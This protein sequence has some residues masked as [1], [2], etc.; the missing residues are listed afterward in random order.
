MHMKYTFLLLLLVFSAL[1]GRAQI[2][3]SRLDIGSV[4]LD[5]AF[6]QT[7]TIKGS[8]LEKMPFLNLSDAISAWLYGAYTTPA[9]LRYVVDGNPVADVNAYSIFDV[10]EVVL[11]Q[12]AAALI[13]TAPGQ[14]ELVL[15]R[16][17]RRTGPYGVTAA[18][19]TGLIGED[20]VS[21]MRFFHNYY[22][23]AYLNRLKVSLGVSAN[24][25]RDATVSDVPGG[26]IVTPPNWQRWR[27]NGYFDWR[28]DASNQIEVTMNYT[29][30]QLN[31]L[32][33]PTAEQAP[34]FGYKES[35]YQHYLT[36]HLDWRGEW[37]KGWTNDLQATYLHSTL[38]TGM[39]EVI[40]E[41]AADSI[42]IE[43]FGNEVKSYHL[44]IRDHLAFTVKAGGWT[45][46]PSIN[47]S[48]EHINEQIASTEYDEFT[49]STLPNL[50]QIPSVTTSEAY[51]GEKTNPIQVVP[52]VDVSYKR[53][54]EFMAGA[55]ISPGT[56]SP[57]GNGN[58]VYPYAG[59]TI[60]LLRLKNPE[61][62]ESLK[63]FG[64]VVS[65][66]MGS[67][68]GY[69]LADF[70]NWNI[71]TNSFVDFL[72]LQLNATPPPGFPTYWTWEA[73]TRYTGVNGR[74]AV[75]YNFEH[76]IS[77]GLG[78]NGYGNIF[79][80]TYPRW[81]SSLQHLD[82]RVKV[83]DAERVSW[84]SGFNVTVLRT[85]E[86]NEGILQL[87]NA[88]IGDVAPGP[89]T[90]TGGWVNRIQVKDFSAGLDLLYH[91]NETSPVANQ[92]KLNS[93]ATPNV[94]LAYRLHFGRATV[95]ELFVDSRDLIQS[96]NSDVTDP[97]R[98]YTVGGKLDL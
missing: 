55:L 32:V 65:R 70:S 98:Y 11:V 59:A 15:I 12:H 49:T 63:L 88:P 34:L 77:S 9:T 92:G 52:G 54:L 37:A 23:G 6:T 21:K 22:A 86:N 67:Y 46:E 74:L 78:T 41:S 76:R 85:T 1:S 35:G 64:S 84:R 51:V 90:W 24:Y 39:V 36:P 18:A 19:Q 87:D 79:E 27:L 62:D 69:T 20:G 97:R 25:I 44:W 2:D 30:Q 53:A 5:K 14:T 83:V 95:L 16:T 61:Q 43:N 3:T 4:T 73:G 80:S 93:A 50:N 38:S 31:G 10:E 96:A 89:W 47:L 13:G 57:T 82:I 56:H 48:Y 45:I 58:R 72:N 40:G 17:K 75:S 60:D 81:Y 71:Q 68:Q 28:P 7:L 8:D 29:P 94:Y 33:N 91:F 42:D 26:A 66:T